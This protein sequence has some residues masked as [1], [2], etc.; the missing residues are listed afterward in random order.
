MNRIAIVSAGVV[1]LMATGSA[2]A[3]PPPDSVAGP[4][5][6]CFKYSTFDLLAGE[7]V[8]AVSGSPESMEITIEGPAGRYVVAESEIFAPPAHL[9]RRV[10]RQAKT[11]VYAVPGNEVRYAVYGRA[12]FAP[13]EDSLIVW[14]SGP[15]LTGGATDAALYARFAVA[16]PD[17]AK[18]IHTFTY[19]WDAYLPD[20]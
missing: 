18:C 19:S 16:D 12:S 20:E 11:T 4:G 13:R 8:V 7:R 15:A 14:I 1:A 6:L 9:G 3:D 10:A 5:L 17:R 2:A